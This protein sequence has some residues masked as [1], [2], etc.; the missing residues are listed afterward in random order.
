MET[1]NVFDWYTLVTVV[2]VI[3]YVILHPLVTAHL[4]SIKNHQ[5]Q[6]ALKLTDDL[7]GFIVPELAVMSNLSNADRKKE[8]IRFVTSKLNDH[9]IELSSTVVSAAVE[10]AYQV[11]K[12]VISGDHH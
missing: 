3:G 9:G 12:H 11:Y 1:L 7:A 2:I 8:A 4:A 10:T 5:L 6:Q